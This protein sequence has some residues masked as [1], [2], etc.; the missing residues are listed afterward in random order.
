MIPFKRRL[1]LIFLI[2]A[3]GIVAIGIVYFNVQHRDFYKS[4]VNQLHVIA[5]LKQEQISQWRKNLIQ[6]MEHIKSNPL[7]RDD[8]EQQLSSSVTLENVQTWMRNINNT[9]GFEGFCLL[10]ST[11]EMRLSV[12]AEQIWP[13]QE[14]QS[15][16]ENT[17]S[18]KQVYISDLVY[19]PTLEGEESIHMIAATPIL[20]E[21]ERVIGVIAAIV[22]PYKELYALIQSWPLPSQSAEILMVRREGDDIVFL[23]ELR[24]QDNTALKL[25]LSIFT[26][27][28]PA[29]WA[30]SGIET[31]GE[32]IDYRGIPVIA[33]TR[34]IEG[35]SWAIVVK[36]DKAEAL[37]P[38]QQQTSF[39]VV[40]FSLLI[41]A[42]G[43]GVY[44]S[45]LIKQY[46]DR[47]KTLDEAN[48][49]NR[50]LEEKVLERTW[51]LEMSVAELQ[52]ANRNLEAFSY[53]VSHD[54]RAPLRGIDGF[55]RAVLEEYHERLDEQGKEYLNR[56]R[57]AAQRMG[58]LI[59]DLLQLS[60]ISLSPLNIRKIDISKMAEEI[61]EELKEENPDNHVDLTV[62]PGIVAYG[63]PRLIR[64][65]LYNLMA[66]AWKFTGKSNE[67]KVWI[68]A[69]LQ[70]AVRKYN[71]HDNG[72]GFDMQYKNKLFQPFQRLHSER[73]YPG[74]GIGL[75]T[76][77]RIVQR[78][79]GEVGAQSTPGGETVFYFTLKKGGLS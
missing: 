78:H 11:G 66:N 9:Y 70:G 8:L 58:M 46:R 25:R 2:L 44:I 27:D 24:H 67:P 73:E 47:S 13:M 65:A 19:D 36:V 74:T 75:A 68:D 60:K 33:A 16:F 15:A 48:T 35:S 77:E 12:G 32:G 49:L 56:L 57:A 69:A 54:L 20:S 64:I 41:A 79:G 76:V 1:I 42:I 31:I 63:D 50:E 61:G 53:S 30:V 6:D 3:C 28:L 37:L 34:S 17:T 4:A 72:V 18:N 26:Q 29:V 62:A 5:D 39:I 7:L 21:D 59:D 43:G 40:L 51:Q 23:N 55:S 71:V 45:Y 38:F 22:S 52:I 14:V 10:D